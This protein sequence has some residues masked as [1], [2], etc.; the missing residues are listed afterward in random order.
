MI[1]PNN[2]QIYKHKFTSRARGTKY[3]KAGFAMPGYAQVSRRKFRTTTEAV[4]YGLR[5]IIRWKRL[6]AAAVELQAAAAVPVP[7]LAEE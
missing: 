6:Y 1:N 3:Y 7:V 5:V 4:S 2:L